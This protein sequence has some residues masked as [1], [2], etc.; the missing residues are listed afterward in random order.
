MTSLSQIL[1]M[2]NAAGKNP[3]TETETTS[4]VVL[5]FLW[6]AGLCMTRSEIMINQ[7]LICPRLLN[8]TNF[9]ACAF[10]LLHNPGAIVSTPKT[11]LRMLVHLP[12]IGHAEKNFFPVS[13]PCISLLL[14]FFLG[15]MTRPGLLGPLK[16]WARI[17]L[18]LVK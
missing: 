7:T 1:G 5:T 16:I 2:V 14:G 11:V 15:Q 12:R 9:L 8:H 10:V 4:Q 13:P 6:P 18:I 3:M 17:P